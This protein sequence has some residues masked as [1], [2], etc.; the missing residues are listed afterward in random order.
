[1]TKADLN[2]INYILKICDSKEFYKDEIDSL[3]ECDENQLLE[4]L[5]TDI[6]VLKKS[7]KIIYHEID[8]SVLKQLVDPLDNF[9]IIEISSSDL[10]IKS[11][12]IKLSK[13]S[14]VKDILNQIIFLEKGL[15]NN[16]LFFQNILLDEDN[17]SYCLQEIHPK[18]SL[19]ELSSK[20][21]KILFRDYKDIPHI[22]KVKKDE[23]I[24]HSKNITE[25][26]NKKVIVKKQKLPTWIN[27]TGKINLEN[28]WYNVSIQ[29][30]KNKLILTY[31]SFFNRYFYGPFIL[32]FKNILSY[33]AK[34]DG[35]LVCYYS[36]LDI[37]KKIIISSEATFDIANRIKYWQD[38]TQYHYFN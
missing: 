9:I 13:K 35:S 10:K 15:L 30:Y 34:Y 6:L 29:F 5:V 28:K 25:K 16:L 20:K 1:M 8:Y 32:Q 33:N 11:C 36:D 7:K 14:L 21:I 24:Y 19:S 26:S 38:E 31:K 27:L 17:G 2:P 3:F 12:F 4:N 18:S 37:K 23:F 22:K